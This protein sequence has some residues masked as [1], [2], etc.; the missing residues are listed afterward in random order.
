MDIHAPVPAA[1]RTPAAQL[2]SEGASVSRQYLIF[3]LGGESFAMDILQIREIIEFGD[4]TTVPMM[5]PMVRGV[6]NLR[7]AVVPVIDL[8][9]RFG[10]DQTLIGRR[11]CIVILQLEEAAEEG[12]PGVSQT[13][14]I[15][16]DGVTEVLD[17]PA[18]DLE[19]APNFGARIRTEFI[20][21]MARVA[22][23]FIILLDMARVLSADEL[24][25]LAAMAGSGIPKEIVQ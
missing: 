24:S 3:T 11:T 23:R 25:T 6:I 10:R 9:A 15:V 8:S 4:L 19:P 13:L 16:V 14:G 2:A 7:G 5:P 21:A 18:G 22:G 12:E 20:A 1:A 17:I